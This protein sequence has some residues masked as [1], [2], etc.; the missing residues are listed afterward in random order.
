MLKLTLIGVL[1]VCV[2]VTIHALGTGLWFQLLKKESLDFRKISR[3]LLVLIFTSVF[4]LFLHIIEIMLWAVM[5]LQL[6][7]VDVLNS[8][9]EAFYFSI[10]TFTTLGYGDITLGEKW[11]IL[12]GIEAVNGVLLIGW[13]TALLFALIQNA[14]KKTLR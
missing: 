12:S 13:T 8:H 11:R 1:M 3:L 2:T 9:L 14:L 4:F 6:V 10:V 5:Y 7:T